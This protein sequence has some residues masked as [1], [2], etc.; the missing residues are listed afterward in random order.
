MKRFERYSLSKYHVGVLPSA[1]RRPIAACN[2]SPL[3]KAFLWLTLLFL[4]NRFSVLPV[5][6]ALAVFLMDADVMV[7]CRMDADVMGDAGNR[8]NRGD[9]RVSVET[10]ACPVST[11][12]SQI[13]TIRHLA[14][15]GLDGASRRLYI[16]AAI[17]AVHP[18]TRRYHSVRVHPATR[19]PHSPQPHLHLSFPLSL[20]LSSR[21]NSLLFLPVPPL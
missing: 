3:L 10:W 15:R 19:Q 11:V 1:L 16:Y 6:F 14:M 21:R 4:I 9:S 7:G 12:E 13:I 5:F 8:M 18:A 20:L 2:Y 17:A